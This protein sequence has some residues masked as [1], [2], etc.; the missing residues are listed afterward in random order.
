MS[1]VTGRSV[2]KLKL[3]MLKSLSHVV[4]QNKEQEAQRCERG[5][6]YFKYV[7]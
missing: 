1:N 3:Q 6:K 4:V 5:W 2:L 7:E